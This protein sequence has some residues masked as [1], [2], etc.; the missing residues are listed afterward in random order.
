MNEIL[1]KIQS[2]Q[3]HAL[4]FETPYIPLLPFENYFA[5]NVN[6]DYEYIRAIS[7]ET[8]KISD[9][10]KLS[11]LVSEK[12]TLKKYFFIQFSKITSETQNALLKIV[13][14]PSANTCFVFFCS[15][16]KDLL[17][18]LLS[19]LEQFSAKIEYSDQ[20]KTELLGFSV[21]D[22]LKKNLQEKFAF[23]KEISDPKS[24]KF[25]TKKYVSLFFAELELLSARTRKKQL[26]I[27]EAHAASKKTNSSLKIL[28]DNLAIQLLDEA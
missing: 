2:S 11:S 28:L 27:V 26:A 8:L 14:E 5:N 9:V 7:Y 17:P 10:R 15:S 12:T 20:E 18:T 1:Q 21:H 19:R 13:E 23:H 4:L 24:K 22:Y 16:A 6:H 3:H 25:L